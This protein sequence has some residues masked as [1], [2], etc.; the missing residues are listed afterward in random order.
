MLRAKELTDYLL[1]FTANQDL[2]ILQGKK[3]VE[4]RMAGL[5][6]GLAALHWLESGTHDFI[7]AAGDDWTD[8]DL[9]RVLP[10]EACTI[11]VGLSTSLA[12]FNVINHKTIINLLKD[13]CEK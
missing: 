4:I 7:L 13:L 6:K 12:R 5:N 2:Q 8:E 1:N 11:K 9:F 3:V 10:K